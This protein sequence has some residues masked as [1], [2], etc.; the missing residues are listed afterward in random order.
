MEAIIGLNEQKEEPE[1][2]PISNKKKIKRNTKFE[3]VSTVSK[4]PTMIFQRV[5]KVLKVLIRK[6]LFRS[7]LQV[8]W[9][10]MIVCDP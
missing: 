1:V 2:R 9:I 4:K 10:Q 5:G 7:K 3:N 6:T 8:H